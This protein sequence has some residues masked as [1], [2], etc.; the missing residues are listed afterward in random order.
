MDR[1]K[2]ASA[3]TS[4]KGGNSANNNNNVD[5]NGSQVSQKEQDD[6]EI[7]L[8]NSF[9]D[10]DALAAQVEFDEFIAQVSF[11]RTT[12]IDGYSSTRIQ[13]TFEPFKLTT[14]CQNFVLFFENEDYTK[15]IPITV[16]GVCVDVPVYVEKEE[17]DLN[18][19]VYEQFYRQKIML[20]N[21]GNNSMKIQLFFPKDFKQYLEFNPTL[22]YIQG[23]GSFEIWLKFRPDRSILTNCKKYLVKQ[24]EEPAKDPYEEFTMS[25]P[26]KITGANQVLP[27]KFNIRCVFAVNAISFSPQNINFGNLFN[28]SASRVTLNMENHSLL[29]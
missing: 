17:Y 20:F 14:I 23:N 11:K 18:V 28:H 4:N 7:N 29:P 12:E 3:L 27:V 9:E 21:R 22:G 15:P 16:K 8:D 6:Q 13:F 24:D 19:L 10:V 26:I 1:A 2:I 25:I 5:E